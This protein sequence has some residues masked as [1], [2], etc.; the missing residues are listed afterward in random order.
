[1]NIFGERQD[2]SKFVPMTIKKILNGDP[3]FCH[4]NEEGKSGS[5]HWIYVGALVKE[6]FNLL[7]QGVAGETYHIV[8]PEMTNLEIIRLVERGLNRKCNLQFTRPGPSHDLRYSIRNTKL[9]YDVGSTVAHLI[10]TA[11]WYKA[12]QDWLQ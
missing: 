9:T 10:T 11:L 1:M 12:N 8:G 4:V 5:R 2:T 7:D 3:V 6:I